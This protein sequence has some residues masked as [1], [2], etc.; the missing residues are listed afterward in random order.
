MQERSEVQAERRLPKRH[1][2]I[3]APPIHP[4]VTAKRRHSSLMLVAETMTGR[5]VGKVKTEGVTFQEKGETK[6]THTAPPAVS[7]ERI[8]EPEV[9]GMNE[10]IPIPE[11]CT[12]PIKPR[13]AGTQIPSKVLP[14]VLRTVVMGQLLAPLP[15]RD[16]WMRG[17]M[18]AGPVVLARQASLHHRLISLVPLG[19]PPSKCCLLSHLNHSSR[20]ASTNASSFKCG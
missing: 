7:A 20:C 9:N 11:S 4:M 10:H 16:L 19:P 13:N 8:I 18:R 14:K 6:E 17:V 2:P 1:E 15:G 3:Q 5:S 12:A